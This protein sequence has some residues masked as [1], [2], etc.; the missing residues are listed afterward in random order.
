MLK[1]I[2]RVKDGVILWCTLHQRYGQK[3][4]ILVLSHLVKIIIINQAEVLCMYSV[5]KFTYS[6]KISPSPAN[7]EEV[8][9]TSDEISEPEEVF[10]VNGLLT[11]L[12][13]LLANL[14]AQIKKDSKEEL[15]EWILLEVQSSCN[16]VQL[17]S[18]DDSTSIDELSRDSLKEIIE[19]AFLKANQ[20]CERTGTLSRF[21]ELDELFSPLRLSLIKAEDP[22]EVTM[23]G[24]LLTAYAERK[25]QQALSP[26]RLGSDPGA[27]SS[28][29]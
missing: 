21:S 10:S 28:C 18:P 29:R 23:I 22:Y 3:F 6:G 7:Y 17:I 11:I 12:K 20:D 2:T 15:M 1:L 14:G 25:P 4:Y 13:V 27:L 16:S 19:S 26:Q 8:S 24:L 5:F 9:T